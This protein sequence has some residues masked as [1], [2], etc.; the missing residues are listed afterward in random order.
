L[1]DS[2]TIL[3]KEDL[4]EFLYRLKNLLDKVDPHQQNSP[5]TISIDN[6]H[7]QMSAKITDLEHELN[8]M[9]QKHTLLENS[10]Y[11]LEGEIKHLRSKN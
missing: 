3:K 6:T 4:I 9:K 11:R 2:L 5:L 8:M 7:Q 10:I 1:L